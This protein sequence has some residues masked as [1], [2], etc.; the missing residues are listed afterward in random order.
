MRLNLQQLQPVYV[1][2]DRTKKQMKT[3]GPFLGRW[4]TPLPLW[5]FE[6]EPPLSVPLPCTHTSQ[7]PLPPRNLM[8]SQRRLGGATL[9]GRLVTH[10]PLAQKLQSRGEVHLF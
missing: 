1:A 5:Q 8:P 10:A 4:L 2:N 7:Q 3:T 9:K 6:I